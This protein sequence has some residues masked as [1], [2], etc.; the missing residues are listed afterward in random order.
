MSLDPQPDE[1]R[2]RVDNPSGADEPRAQPVDAPMHATLLAGHSVL[3]HA[4]GALYLPALQTLLVADLHVGKAQ[5]F[6]RLG[7]PVPHGT[8]AATL[9]RLTDVL[10]DTGAQRLVLLGDFLHAAAG[11]SAA[12][13]AALQTWRAA[14]AAVAITLVRGNHDRHAG[15]PPAAWGIETVNEPLRVGGLALCH[16]PRPVAGAYVLAGHWHPCVSVGWRAV[17]GRLRLPCF[18]FGAEGG[19]GV[20]ILPA[21]GSFTGMHP[22]ERLAGDRVFAVAGTAIREIPPAAA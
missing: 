21:F 13:M 8:T 7:V 20:G 14:H 12:T 22:I 5:T 6:R 15:D 11:R 4:S 3:L 2:A 17:G 16:H 18:W 9:G 1:P 19:N 10:R